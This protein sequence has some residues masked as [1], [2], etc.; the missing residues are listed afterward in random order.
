MTGTRIIQEGD[1]GDALY[2]IT[3]PFET[4]FVS[5]KVL[6]LRPFGFE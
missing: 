5:R 1:A 3:E 2:V 4:H 6:S